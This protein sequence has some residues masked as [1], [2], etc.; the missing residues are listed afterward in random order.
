VGDERF[1]PNCGATL[2]EQVKPIKPPAKRPF[3]TAPVVALVVATVIMAILIPSLFLPLVEVKDSAS[4]SVPFQA[5]VDRIDL[6]FRGDMSDVDL[7]FAEMEGKLLNIDVEMDGRRGVLSSE[8]V[9]ELNLGHR[10]QTV[11]TEQ[12]MFIEI[13]VDSTPELT[14]FPWGS[15]DCEVTID[16]DRICDV[17]ART[18]M[19]TVRMDVP[20][21][22]QLGEVYLK[23]STGRV[24]LRLDEG[25]VVSDDITLETGTGEVRLDWERVSMLEDV[26]LV[27][28]TD[29]GS[30]S[31][32]V[33][34]EEMTSDVEMIAHTDTGTV[35]LRLDIVD[36]VGAQITSDVDVG[37]IEVIED[38]GFEGVDDFL[39]SEN[40][41]GGG[42][43]MIDLS[44]DTGSIEI[45]ASWE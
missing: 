4:E 39:R 34:Q 13:S 24:D 1:C 43:F 28:D 12:V 21:D 33:D 5:T 32:N 14:L 30:I 38:D 36:D 35:E 26:A 8:T 40:Y 42:N 29:T 9:L 31:M 37:D 15:V 6:E 10:V 7:V 22:V 18:D 19:G 25:A 27:L 17:Y 16:P 11:G 41:P 20:A 23:S 44:T 2:R 3:W 45:E